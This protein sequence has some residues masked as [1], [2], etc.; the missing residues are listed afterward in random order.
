MEVTKWLKPSG[1]VSRIGEPRLRLWV[2]TSPSAPSNF[3]TGIKGIAEAI[4]MK[5]DNRA[6]M[7]EAGGILTVAGGWPDR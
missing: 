3:T 6:G 4:F 5:T 7:S 2:K 1:S